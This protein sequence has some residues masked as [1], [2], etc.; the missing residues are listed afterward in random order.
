MNLNTSSHHDVHF[1]LLHLPFDQSNKEK[2]KE[3]EKKWSLLVT[4]IAS[5]GQI[6]AS[7]LTPPPFFIGSSI[8]LKL[9]L[10]RRNGY[11]T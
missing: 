10:V 8:L 4:K 3:K 9:R 5:Q 7:Q 1:S 6:L 2:E 11:P